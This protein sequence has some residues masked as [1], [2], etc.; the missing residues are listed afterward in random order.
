V[1][2]YLDGGMHVPYAHKGLDTNLDTGSYTTTV[3]DCYSVQVRPFSTFHDTHCPLEGSLPFR[4][5][6]R[7]RHHHHHHHH[8]HHPPPH[9]PV[10][11]Q[12]CGAASEASARIGSSP[13][14]YAHLFPHTM[15]NRYGPWCDVNM[16]IPVS[17]GHCRVVYDYFL[18][19]A[20]LANKTPS[21]AEE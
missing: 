12:S 6:R 21:E 10:S 7:H 9:H 2:N 18:E 17:A 14:V 4:L 13:A 15:I 20:F 5:R 1:D 8:H 11:P 19:E 3:H 16:V